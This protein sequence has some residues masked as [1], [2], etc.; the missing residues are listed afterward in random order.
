MLTI[1]G[2]GSHYDRRNDYRAL[3]VLVFA[4]GFVWVW[5]AEEMDMSSQISPKL[6]N[7]A[8]GQDCTFNLDVCNYNP[9]TVVLCHAPSELKGMGNKSPDWW[10]GFGCSSCHEAIDN[11]KVDDENEAWMRAIFR[12]QNIMIGKGL[13]VIP[14]KQVRR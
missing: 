12:T 6:R 13:I 2:R 8:R 7:S 5:E 9:E 11:H 1:N 14:F 10:A 4:R 3:R